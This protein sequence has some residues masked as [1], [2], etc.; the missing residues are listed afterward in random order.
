[1]PNLIGLHDIEATAIA[2]PDTWIV[3][4][5]AL[6]ERPQPRQYPTS[7]NVI[8]RLNWG[9]GT[10][11]TLP[12]P[13][14]Y[15]MFAQRVAQ[16]VNGSSGCSRWIIGN[17]SNLPRE[18]PDHQPIMPWHYA[19]CYKMCRDAIHALPGHARDEV[20]VA[21]SGPWNDE[22]KYPGNANG[23]WILYFADTLDFCAA[24]LDGFALHAYCHAYDPA[25]VTSTAR[26][27]AP[28]QHRYFEF[29]TYRDY[30]AAI[31]EEYRHLPAYITEA[32]GDGPWQAVG[33]MPAMLAEINDWNY[34]QE[35]KIH[36]VTFYRYPRYDHFFIEGRAD[37]TAEYHAAVARGYE[38]PESGPQPP[39]PTPPDPGPQPPE[40]PRPTPEPDRDIDPALAVRGVTFVYAQPAAGQ[41]YWRIKKAEWLDEAEADAAG[42]DHHI[43]GKLLRDGLEVA[44]VPLSVTWPS[45]TYTLHSKGDDPNA[46]Y[47]YD[48]PMGPSLNEYA[49]RIV[50]GNPS[51][52]ASGIGMG[53]NG[54]PNVHTSTWIDW[55]WTIADAQPP[56]PS[57]PHTEYVL[58]LIGANLRDEPGQHG[59][60]L[61][62]VPYAEAVTV[63]SKAMQADGYEWSETTYMLA[64]GFIRSDLLSVQQP[65]HVPQPDPADLILIWPV[66]TGTVTQWFGSRQIDYRPFGIDSHDGID[67]GCPTGTAVLAVC[68]GKV[69]AV[70][71]D[72][73]GFGLYVII[74]HEAHGFHSLYGHL[75]R[76]MVNV[77]EMVTRG[78][79]IG[80]VG[81]SGNSSGSHLH[82]SLR[83]GSE[84]DYYRVHTGHKQG[85]SDPMAIYAVINRSD[86]NLLLP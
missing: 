77:G 79:Q 76:Q 25:L 66:T 6:S 19:A 86:P 74:Y 24:E 81:S 4:T 9:Y 51:D 28:F 78:K 48:Y 49:I 16:Y 60:V 39:R 7:L 59:E 85:A 46:S 11:G 13:D 73:G 27:D 15:P 45:G 35:P 52:S 69:M 68:H 44:G 37:V 31:R 82:F 34:S 21:A 20:L 1:M 71:N 80:E 57:T 30:C 36:C 64:Y 33:L 10:T 2:A 63:H 72:D 84:H 26:M 38:S 41:G 83:V 61:V 55:Q 32:N 58:P 23:D 65:E 3:D 29:Y 40:P 18:W 75:N 47:S 62:S 56:T 42:P 8:T 5:V 70:G 53:M 54:N 43:L 22:L 50:D 67:I 17:E 14:Q 12:V